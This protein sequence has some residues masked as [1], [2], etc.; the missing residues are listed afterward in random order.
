LRQAGQQRA[1]ACD[2][3]ALLAL[4]HGAA[5]DDVIDAFGIDSGGQ[6]NDLP[7]AVCQHVGRMYA[8]ESATRGFGHWGTG[9]GDNIC[10]LDIFHGGS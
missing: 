9:G 3:H 1:D 2:I 4:R 5:N 7:E 6:R 10:F 8:L